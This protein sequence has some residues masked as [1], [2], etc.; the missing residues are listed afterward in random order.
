[1]AIVSFDEGMNFIR[2]AEEIEVSMFDK[3][4]FGI[5][6]FVIGLFKK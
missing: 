6:N 1:M 5:V 2:D 4:K 3:I